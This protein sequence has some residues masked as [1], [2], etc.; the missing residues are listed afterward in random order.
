MMYAEIGI[1][2]VLLVVLGTGGR[3]ITARLRRVRRTRLSDRHGALQLQ[4]THG[5]RS[6]ARAYPTSGS[7]NS[8]GLRLAFERSHA[9]RV[10]RRREKREFQAWLDITSQPL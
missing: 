1:S 5:N 2:A 8:K 6:A 7:A 10:Q 4:K 3:A 9:K